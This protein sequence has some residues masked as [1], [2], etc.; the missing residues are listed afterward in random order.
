MKVGVVDDAT[1]GTSDEN[2]PIV[3]VE[4]GTSA[5]PVPQAARRRAPANPA[6]IRN[7]YM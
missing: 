6:V 7:K 5:E 1:Y 4:P 3:A 2:P